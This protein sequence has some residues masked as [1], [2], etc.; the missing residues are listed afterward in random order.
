M[1][2]GY[3]TIGT[4]KRTI[5]NAE[6]LQFDDIFVYS[7]KKINTLKYLKSIKAEHTQR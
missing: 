1:C 4:M 6:M 2:K 3:L 7:I 5:K